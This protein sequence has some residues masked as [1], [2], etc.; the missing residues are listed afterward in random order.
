MRMSSKITHYLLVFA[1]LSGI[2]QL[3]AKPKK[4]GWLG[5]GIEET[6]PSMRADYKLGNRDGLLITSVRDDSPAHTAGLKED[7]VIIRFD[8]KNATTIT[9]F[10]E[11]VK[12]TAPETKVTVAYIRDGKERK[13]DVTIGKRKSRRHQM[14]WMTPGGG[15]NFM[16]ISD[17]PTLGIKLH[18][19]DENLSEYFSGAA[20]GA[21][22][23]L[24]VIEDSPA[25]KAGI[26][27]GDI[28]TKVDGETIEEPDDI[29]ALLEEYEEGDEV[30]IAYLRKGK[31]GNAKAVLK[32]NEHSIGGNIFNLDGD[33][34]GFEMFFHDDKDGGNRKDVEII[35]RDKIDNVK[36]KLTKK[37]TRDEII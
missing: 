30:A 17:R 32:G 3:Q 36:R 9:A 22:M 33:G 2:T 18:A 24:E 19:L 12:Q 28:I 20:A 7:D 35:L 25:A 11:Q 10:V 34:E 5:V 31:A 8:G 21:A 16:F 14:S 13:T 26:K 4:K 29:I 15:A 1:L 6:T 37:K 23:V 27:A